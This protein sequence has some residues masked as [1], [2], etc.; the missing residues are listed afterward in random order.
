[1]EQCIRF[2][3]KKK[4]PKDLPDFWTE[5]RKNLNET[6]QSS[7]S[8][9]KDSRLLYEP[10][11]TSRQCGYKNTSL[12]TMGRKEQH[13]ETFTENNEDWLNET[14]VFANANLF[15]MDILVYWKY[16]SGS[17]CIRFIGRA[18]GVAIGLCSLCRAMVPSITI[19]LVV[20]Q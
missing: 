4:Q 17:G 1:M 12:R 18:R 2:N 7:W 5:A 6:A 3:N 8:K 13:F 10:V 11:G 16:G 19:F 15:L 14:I 20:S 9:R